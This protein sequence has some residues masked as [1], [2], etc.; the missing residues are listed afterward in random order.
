MVQWQHAAFAVI[1]FLLEPREKVSTPKEKAQLLLWD[2][3]QPTIFAKGKK[4][5][6][7]T[8]MAETLGEDFLCKESPQRQRKQIPALQEYYC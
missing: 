4:G 3:P 1:P 8:K 6:A 7:R 2:E 5:K